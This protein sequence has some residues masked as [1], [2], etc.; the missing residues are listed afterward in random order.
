MVNKCVVANCTSGYVTGE[1]K[2]SFQFP[3]DIELKNKWI[4]FVNRK[5][6]QPTKY[7]VICIEH[8]DKTYIKYGKKCKLRWEM[9]PV[10]TIHP[11]I[12]GKNSLIRIPKV[13][14]QSPRKRVLEDEISTFEALDK[15]NSFEH[16]NELHCPQ[17]F[18]FQRLDGTVQFYNLVF[19]EKMNGRPEVMEC[20]SVD[21]NLHVKLSYRG[22]HV[23][24]PEWFRCNQSCK[25]T[26]LSMLENL[27]TH[28]KNKG[29]EFNNILNELNEVQFYQPKGRPKY[30]SALIRFALLL[31]YNSLQTYKLLLEQLPLPSLSLLEKISSGKVDP[32]KVVKTLLENGSISE[33]C[34]LLV[35][36][37]YL[38]K[39]VQY[40]GGS[41]VGAD[42][43]GK[44][45]KGIV[46]F[47]IVSLKKTIACVVKSCPESK[48]NGQ[49]LCNEIDD[50]ISE[51]QT[52]GLKVRAVICD[53]HAS[54]VSAFSLLMRKYNTEDESYI[55]HHAYNGNIKTYL[56]YDIVHLIKNVR[57]N[58]MNKRKF[59]FPSYQFDLFQDAINVP[60]GYLCWGMFYD[61]YE[62][63]NKLQCNLRKAPKLTFKATHPGN[64]KQ[65]VS[66]AL[67]IFDEKTSS[68]IKSYY[69]GRTDAANFLNLFYKLFLVCNSKQQF[70]RSNKVGNAIVSGDN[71]CEFLDSVADWIE[72][73]SKSP[74]M[75]L[76]KQTS[77]ALVTTLRGIS[78]LTKELLSSGNYDYVLTSRLQSDP[79][80]RRFSKYRQ[81]SGGRFL[82]GL[83]EVNSSEKI[84]MLSS[85]LK[86]DINFWETD[87]VSKT[88]VSETVE[89]ILKEIEKMA[90]EIFEIEL[91]N[92]TKEVAVMVAGYIAKKLKE[93][94]QCTVCE[95]KFVA[96]E[97]T[98][99][100]DEYL[101]ILSRGGLT[102]PSPFLRD[103]VFQLFGTLDFIID[104]LERFAQ[105]K[106]VRNVAE[107]VLEN[108][109]DAYP[110]YAC[111]N[112]E[113]VAR[114]ITIR[115][116]VN[117]FFNNLQKQLTDSIRKEQIV[118]FKKRQ[119]KKQ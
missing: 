88:D 86:E 17:N 89:N 111:Q 73:W 49:W 56:F 50:C 19:N 78:N 37:M 24:L 75:K 91:H 69:P 13:P 90:T 25:L 31:R 42:E 58:L 71:K 83:R 44:L 79:I 76:T 65:D 40:H 116:V 74:T 30:S 61:L 11:N 106:T 72:E 95:T 21:K 99:D 85:I 105:N 100:F 53:D 20:I 12:G 113:I 46:V 94:I 118:D 23:P 27:V 33:D 48:I 64:N 59:V 16:F 45:Y 41:F 60:A 112:H 109:I 70:N 5:D 36:E 34:V 97:T 29:C 63:D 6:W 51:L 81:M 92:D 55:Y 102:C 119:R 32:T 52:I 82:V 98:I 1:K 110:N 38:Q 68:A 7:S 117:I 28:I 15:V 57:N 14:R 84:L 77:H 107:R 2:P 87:V 93:K 43:N 108:L 4:Y 80:E 9:K 10:P 67:A 22:Y 3:D 54:N 66:L 47:L 101:K 8:F 103:F 96:N 62:Q 26:R 39:G 115:T 104:I 18:S 114:K 35:D